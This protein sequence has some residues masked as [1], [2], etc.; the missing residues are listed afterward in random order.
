MSPVLLY[1]FG[2]W[3]IA[4]RDPSYASALV[5]CRRPGHWATHRLQPSNP[6]NAYFCNRV[7]RSG[8]EKETRGEQCR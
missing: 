3:V 6:P 5:I 8:L 4:R 1:T 2:I 7:Y